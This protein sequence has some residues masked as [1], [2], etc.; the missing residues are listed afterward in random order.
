MKLAVSKD[1]EFDH[2]LTK[3]IFLHIFPLQDILHL[4]LFLKKKNDFFRHGVC[5]PP[6]PEID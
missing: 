2:F 5:P 4:F 6:P 1:P 3:Y